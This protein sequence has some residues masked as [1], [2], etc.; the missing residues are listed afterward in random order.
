MINIAFYHNKTKSLFHIDKIYDCHAKQGQERAILIS[1][2]LY[3]YKMGKFKLN[4]KFVALWKHPEDLSIFPLDGIM[5]S[6][7]ILDHIRSLV[8]DYHNNKKECRQ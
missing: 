8:F 1:P 3:S 6:N 7:D 4:S 5:P 2:I